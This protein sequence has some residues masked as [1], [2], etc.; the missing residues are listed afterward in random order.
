MSHTQ[1]T[2]WEERFDN[3]RYMYD[4]NGLHDISKKELKSFISTEITN[5]INERVREIKK[6]IIYQAEPYD[7]AKWHNNL[8]VKTILN[9]PSLQEL[10][11]NKQSQ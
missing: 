2:G 1:K 5:A 8:S 9:L 7:K 10:P 4:K 6:D 3:L 11:D